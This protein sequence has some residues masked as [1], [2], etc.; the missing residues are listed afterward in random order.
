[1][2]TDSWPTCHEFEPSTAEDSA[3]E[4]AMHIKSVEA[5]LFIGATE[6]SRNITPRVIERY[7]NGASRETEAAK[8]EILMF[9]KK[10]KMFGKKKTKK[11]ERG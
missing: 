4:E 6:T 7:R 9:T 11:E 8:G 2:V 10:Q 5:S 3:R 1:M